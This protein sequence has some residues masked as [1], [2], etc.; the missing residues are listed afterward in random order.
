MNKLLNSPLDPSTTTTRKTAM[1]RPALSPKFTLAAS[2]SL[3]VLLTGCFDTMEEFTLNPDGSGKVVHESTFKEMFSAHGDSNDLRDDLLGEIRTVLKESEGVQAWRDVT[4]KRVDHDRIF[5]RAT[6]YFT[7]L[8]ELKNHQQEAVCFEWRTEPGG[9]LVLNLRTN[10]SKPD[11][12]LAPKE[13]LVPTPKLSAEEQANKLKD[14]RAQYRKARLLMTEEIGSSTHKTLFHLPGKVSKSS[15][16]QT[17]PSGTLKLDF[18]GVSFIEA[19]DK[20]ASNDSWALK[21]SDA[22][23][24]GASTKCSP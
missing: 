24:R 9:T 21:N 3:A 1:K 4:Y 22:F 18:D 6:A 16:F 20:L 19:L 14:D 12:D 10:T 13:E 23:F 7:N 8:S 17:D 15:N 5:F 2:L 11:K